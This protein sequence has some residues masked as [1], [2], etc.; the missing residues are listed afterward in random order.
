M[1]T[2]VVPRAESNVRAAGEGR[3]SELARR[4]S[5]GRF[6]LMADAAPVMIWMSGTDKLCTYFNKNWLDFT[7]L[8]L[9][10]QVGNQ[11]SE[12]V[13]PDDLERCLDTYCRA[14]D[15]RQEFRMVYR[16]R[17]FDG[18]YRWLLDTGVPRFE[19]DG[20]FDG[21]I[22]S[23]I[24]ITDQKRVEEALRASEARLRFLLES[25]HAIPWVADAQTRRFTYVGP[26]A[27]E[28]LG[29]P[30]DDWY[31]DDFWALHI[32]PDDRKATLAFRH[33]HGSREAAIPTISLT[34]GCSRRT[35][36]PSGSMT[37]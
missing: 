3:E 28:L 16:L 32:P 22:G 20:A 27:S 35:G 8:P 31:G 11:W 12:G 5:E 4:D 29:Y 30:T 7:G 15:G 9:E 24:D 17:R 2:Q 37:S 34:T 25:T 21:Y 23:C 36:A 13:H 26:Q 10:R 19:S 18:A 6:R 33:E 14:F 1:N